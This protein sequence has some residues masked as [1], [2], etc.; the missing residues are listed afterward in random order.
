MKKISKVVIPAAGFGTRFLPQTKALPKEMLPIVDKPVIQYVVEEAVASGIEDV[1]IVTG[2]SKRAIED[3][4]DTPN[5]DLVNNLREGNKIH[6]LSEL[7]NI[8]EMANFI[9]IRQKGRYGN[10]TPILSAEPI[11][12]NEP[13][14]VM[15][16]DEFIYAKPPRLKQMI[17]AWN[18]YQGVMVSGVR[19]ETKDHLSRY[20]IADLEKVDN[21]VHRIK[22]I[23]E[24]PLPT[25]AP[26]NLATHGAYILPPEI[27]P[28]LRN[29]KPGKSGE[30]WLVDAINELKR[31]GIPVYA[32]EIK[33]G[34]Y[35]DT[36]NKLEY[37]KTVIEFALQHPEINGEFRKFL[38]QLPL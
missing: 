18:K 32:C 37:L 4:F 1:I 3:H 11:I 8:S 24:K 2:W 31:Q 14:A 20:G 33:N 7:V 22:R 38:K 19:I 30:I 15:W 23:V 25:D 29:L 36:G 17:D 26:S 28:A 13:F 27:F 5:A 16:G 35:Y 10:G 6:L 21:H 9:Y 12:G 34:K